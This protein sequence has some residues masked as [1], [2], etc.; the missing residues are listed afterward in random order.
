MSRK[1]VDGRRSLSMNARGN[2]REGYVLSFGVRRGALTSSSRDIFVLIV[3]D[4]EYFDSL[5][6]FG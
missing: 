1:N 3:D 4:R 5:V 6:Q 2:E